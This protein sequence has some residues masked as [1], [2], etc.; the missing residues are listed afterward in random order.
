L[1]GLL[2]IIAAAVVDLDQDKRREYV[3]RFRAWFKNSRVVNSK[4]E[5]LV[6]YHGMVGELEDGA[7][8]VD[9]IGQNFAADERGFFFISDPKQAGDY[10]TSDPQGMPREGGSVVPVYVSLQRPVVVDDP[11][12]HA[13]GMAA[14]GVVEDVISF[15]DNYQALI[16]EWVDE[17]GADGVIL[18]DE[19]Y[20]P[21][22]EPTKLV[23]AFEPWQIKSI[24]NR[25]EWSEKSPHI[26]YAGAP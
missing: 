7:F 12:L 2:S 1:I 11:F 4:G 3:R 25:G 16:L 24:Y 10:A 6:V 19:T 8:D 23:V 22:G 17:H 26:S 21:D 14:I 18:V 20:R 9:R 5:P 13:E 15:W